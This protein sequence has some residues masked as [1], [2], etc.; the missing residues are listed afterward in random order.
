VD[1][2]IKVR[3]QLAAGNLKAGYTYYKRAILRA[4]S[5]KPKPENTTNSE[6]HLNP[7]VTP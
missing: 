6:A 7:L 3:Q 4:L 1:A 5:Q 2:A